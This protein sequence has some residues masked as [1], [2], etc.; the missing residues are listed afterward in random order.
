MPQCAAI[1]RIVIFRILPPH[2]G[3]IY[4]IELELPQNSFAIERRGGGGGS[5][6][7]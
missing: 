1:I 7:V 3:L 2:A 5:V 6:N 4:T